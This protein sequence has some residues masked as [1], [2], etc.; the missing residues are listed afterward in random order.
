MQLPMVRIWT[1]R[2]KFPTLTGSSQA[3]RHFRMSLG[4]F[5]KITW[6]L[7]NIVEA[8]MSNLHK[9]ICSWMDASS[10]SAAI[11][12][13]IFCLP[14]HSKGVEVWRSR[15]DALWDIH[16][17]GPH[18]HKS[19]VKLSN[20]WQVDHMPIKKSCNKSWINQLF[21]P[22][23]NF[24][25]SQWITPKNYISGSQYLIITNIYMAIKLFH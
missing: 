20:V 23:H 3:S 10:G 6:H 7:Y 15:Y 19:D 18:N 22:T 1:L 11:Q 14:H 4:C 24:S 13:I 5:L 21:E 2:Y 25:S 17:Y 16:P 8:W 9:H 12:N